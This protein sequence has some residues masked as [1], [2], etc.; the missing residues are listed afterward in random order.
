[1]YYKNRLKLIG[2][3]SILLSISS[4]IFTTTNVSADYNISVGDSFK[5]TVKKFRNIAD[6]PLSYAIN[7]IILK[8]NA[9]LTINVS[10]VNPPY[11]IE[12]F[13][14]SEND[15]VISETNEYSLFWQTIFLNRTWDKLTD[16]YELLSYEVQQNSRIWSA[17][18]VEG[19]GEIEA[20]F[21]KEDG[22]LK[23]IFISNYPPLRSVTG[24]KTVEIERTWSGQNASIPI[25]IFLPIFILSLIFLVKTK[26]HKIN[27]VK[28]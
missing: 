1:M 26:K 27:K 8:E 12:Y 16:Y 14:T 17:R 20:E 3:I 4:L 18:L 22:V 10:T 15:G 11:E 19:D 7:D 13:I 24:I 2:L 6:E 23:R 25:Q 5:F 9:I 21:L 28:K